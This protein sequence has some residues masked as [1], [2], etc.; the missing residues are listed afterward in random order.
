M[1]I[2][3]HSYFL[4]ISYI[5]QWYTSFFPRVRSSPY[6]AYV[7]VYFGVFLHVIKL[8]A[9][10][11]DSGAM[12]F[13][14]SFK[15]VLKLFCFNFIS[16]CGQFYVHMG[17][18]PNRMIIKYKYDDDNFQRSWYKLHRRIA[19]LHLLNSRPSFFAHFITFQN[20][21]ISQKKIC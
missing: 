12:Q 2:V 5:K 7:F 20:V 10:R 9:R 21:F 11:K 6:L 17:K 19:E 1:Y 8:S 3:Y 18:I 4:I 13:Q 16:L 14:N 15:T